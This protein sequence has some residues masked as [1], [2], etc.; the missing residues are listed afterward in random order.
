MLLGQVGI[1]YANDDPT[2]PAKVIKEFKKTNEDCL[3]VTGLFFE[4]EMY[5]SQKYEELAKLLSKDELLTKLVM[6]LNSPM[7]KVA[8]CLK[9]SMSKL[10]NVLNSVKDNKN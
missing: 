1:A 2:A 7:T 10:A 3:E 6:D 8:L 9:S 4:G 5:E